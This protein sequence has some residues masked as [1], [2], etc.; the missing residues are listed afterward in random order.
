[1][2]AVRA[3]AIEGDARLMASRLIPQRLGQWLLLLP[4]LLL[5]ALGLWPDAAFS[6]RGPQR[7]SAPATGTAAVADEDPN[8]ARVI[9]KYRDGSALA[10]LAASA[11]RAQHASRLATRLALPMADGRPLGPHT[12]GLQARGLSSRQLVARLAAQPDVEWAAVD[13]RRTITGVVPNDPYYRAGQT[14]ITPAVGQW[15]LRAPDSTA[16]ARRA[17]RPAWASGTC[18]RPTALP[19]RP[20]T[21]RAP[22]Q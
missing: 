11:G 10:Q 3:P 15:Y 9:V 20:S 13:Q 16:L 22:G 17:S 19:S 6:E 4:A 7:L 2:G 5:P 21:P 1:M 14:S 18:A 12:Q 8:N